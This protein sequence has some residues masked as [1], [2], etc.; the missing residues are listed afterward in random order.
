MTGGAHR[1]RMTGGGAD[2]RQRLR[3]P[4][5]VAHPFA[6]VGA[7]PAGN[8]RTANAERAGELLADGFGR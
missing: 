5:A 8:G 4:R 7:G 6:W 1:R 2:L 3:G